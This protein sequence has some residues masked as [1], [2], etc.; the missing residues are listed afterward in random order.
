MC[1][2]RAMGPVI[3]KLSNTSTGKPMT[4]VRSTALRLLR[5]TLSDDWELRIKARRLGVVKRQG[6][7]DSYALLATVVLGVA[8]RGP[9]AIAVIGR[10]LSEVTG[11]RLA[12]SSVWARFTPAFRDLVQLVLDDTIES[13]RCREVRPPGVL[14]GFSDVIAV[15]ATVLKVHDGLEHVWRATRRNTTKAALKVHTWVRAFT[16][17]VLKY[18]LTADAHGDGRAFGVDHQLRGCLVLFDKAYSSPSLWR[19]I[20]TVGGYFLT[21]LPADRNPEIVRVLRR[22]R[23]RARQLPGLRLRDGVRSLSRQYMDVE[24]TFRCKVRRYGGAA[25]NRWVHEE[26][27]II[28]VRRQRGKYDFYVTNAPPDKLPAEAVASTYRLR[29]EVE[30]FFKTAK[31]GSEVD[32]LPSAKQHIVE[33]LIYAA[34]LRATTSMQALATVRADI[35]HPRGL[36][37]NPGQWQKWWNR[38]LRGL[39]DDLVGSQP[40]LSTMEVAVMLSDPNVGRPTNRSTFLMGA[41]AT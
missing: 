22:H 16:G 14:A 18:R 19:R 27:R 26:F 28:A 11:V 24:G 21:P 10:V 4:Q 3:W 2:P 38:R 32:H 7:V 9:T 37:V 34:L 15:D 33:T 40:R 35:A 6:K 20:H 31:T 25:R 17:E 29:W 12:R 1:W 5:A 41:N 36:F 13:S 8:V 30:T 23:G 39:L